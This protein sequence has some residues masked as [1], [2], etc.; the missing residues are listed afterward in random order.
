MNV[1][2]YK[3][4]STNNQ[5]S[6]WYLV[7]PSSIINYTFSPEQNYFEKPFVIT[8]ALNYYLIITQGIQLF[9]FTT[10]EG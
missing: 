10:K 9:L 8:S 2:C 6:Q 5:G 1:V 3:Y 4:K 7:L